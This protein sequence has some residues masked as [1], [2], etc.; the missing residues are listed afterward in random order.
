MTP[1]KK[2]AD[3]T[4]TPLQSEEARNAVLARTA[5]GIHTASGQAKQ[6]FV[7]ENS[8][9]EKPEIPGGSEIEIAGGEPQ[10]DAAGPTAPQGAQAAP[11]I[12]AT[13]GT[14]P[15]N[16][17]ASP[18]GLVPVSAVVAD[19]TQGAKLVQEGL[20]SQE[21]HL[22]GS[23]ADKLSRA[24]IESMSAAELRAVASDRGYDIGGI[25]GSR[26]TRRRFIAAQ[27]N[28]AGEDTVETAEVEQ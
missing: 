16:H 28:D 8:D 11:A 13:N 25:V 27:N 20:D 10:P 23:G 12:L 26:T 14:I 6:D 15:V 18:S 24:K 4:E 2:A 17:V 3:S 19:A 1:R 22:L 21:K 7:N 9:E 5:A